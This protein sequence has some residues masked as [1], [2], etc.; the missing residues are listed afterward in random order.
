MAF[1]RNSLSAFLKYAKN[2]LTEALNGG[3]KVSVV[4]GN[5]SA[6]LDSFTCSM[7]YAYIRTNIRLRPEFSAVCGHVGISTSSLLTL[8]D[9]PYDKLRRENFQWILVDHNKLQGQLG[10][11]FYANVAGVIDHHEEEYAVPASTDPEPRIIER[12]GSCTSLVVCYC[13]QSWDAI[14]LS[15]FS[16]GAAHGQG[17]SAINDN[18]YTQAWD[19]RIA[20][21][22][23]ASVLIDTANLTAPGKVQDVDR[24]AVE[25]LE[26]KIQM[27]PKDAKTWDRESFFKE[28]QEAK[29]NIGGLT[30]DEILIKDYKQWT[31]NGMNLGIS[32]V[33][34]PLDFILAK[35]KPAFEKMLEDFMVSKDLSVFAIMTT[36]A[37]DNGDFQRQLL[38]Q[39]RPSAYGAAQKFVAIAVTNLGLD[40]GLELDVSR[41]T[42]RSTSDMWRNFWW[43]R[44]LS[45]S[46]KQVGPLLRRAMQD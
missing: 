13:R 15:S 28:I 42:E 45:K 23:L 12:A 8:D 21:M 14:S 5:E 29:M 10:E 24:K 22:A 40:E 32:S 4:V 43:Q 3:R 33:V 19:A 25:Y 31:E 11:K 44:D 30:L 41:Q 37:S 6:D 9:L 16:V 38:L 36:S 35:G 46:R 7:L 26:A 17:E 20:K 1:A 34:K 2:N 27:S 39:A 18:A